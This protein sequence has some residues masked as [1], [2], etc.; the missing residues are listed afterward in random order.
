MYKAEPLVMFS[1]NLFGGSG[2]VIENKVDNSKTLETLQ[3]MPQEMANQL[4][5]YRAAYWGGL[6]APGQVPPNAPPYVGAIICF[7][8]LIGFAVL[9]NQHK[10]WILAACLL[11]FMMSWGSYFE[12]FNTFLLNALPGYNKFRVPSMALVIP[13]FLLCMMAVLTLQKITASDSKTD[14]FKEYKKGL[15]FSAGLVVVLLL[16][17]MSSDFAAGSDTELS[18]QVSA[19]PAQVQDAVRNF[20]N[21]LK[22]DRKSLFFSSLIR[23]LLFAGAAAVVL[24]LRV[25]NKIGNAVVFSIVGILAFADIITVDSK[26]LNSESYQDATDYNNQSFFTPTAADQQILQDKGYYR[27][28]DLRQGLGTLTQGAN[29][30]YFHNSIGGY[31]PAKLSIYQDLIEHQLSN[32]PASLP[33]LNMLNTK[34]IIQADQSGKESIYP[35]EQNLGAAWFVNAVKFENTP[36]EVMNDLGNFHPKDTAIVFAAD[37]SLVSYTP[38]T[39]SSSI[40]LIKN[41]NDVITYRYSSP[42]NRFAVFSEIYYKPGWK[43]TIDGKELPIIRTNYVLRGLSLP[44][45]QNKE[46]RFEFHPSSFYSGKQLSLISGILILLALAAALFMEYRNRAKAA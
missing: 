32:F 42:V 12:G 20:L 30:A 3:S 2:D 44:A 34:Y 15:L 36:Q 4:A 25:K 33:L 39:D 7:I 41:D 9:N 45:G 8:A 18:K 6:S 38:T 43:A 21:A 24:W 37:K 29:T 27:V 26:Y 17:Y 10:W 11:A 5:G 14:L 31:H 28:F 40:Q 22:D 13:T 35:N 16:V 1:P 46:I 19:L 23:S